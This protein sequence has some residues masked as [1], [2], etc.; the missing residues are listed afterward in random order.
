MAGKRD[1]RAST[2]VCT[3]G[4]GTG[5]PRVPTVTRMI[6]GCDGKAMHSGL[7]PRRALSSMASAP[8]CLSFLLRDSRLGAALF[9]RPLV[10]S[11]SLGLVS[12]FPIFSTFVVPRPGTKEVLTH[13]RGRG[14]M[15]EKG[16][17]WPLTELLMG[18]C[19][20]TVSVLRR[21]RLGTLRL[22]FPGA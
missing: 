3:Q 10:L 15:K 21:G 2:K 19:R 14:L 12:N 17:R 9:L 6:S 8:T 20:Q 1:S 18:Q 11:A 7:Y 13:Q 4:S 16:D 22:G 5:P